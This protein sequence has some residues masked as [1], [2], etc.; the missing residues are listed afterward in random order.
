M[1]LPS[2]WGSGILHIPSGFRSFFWQGVVYDFFVADYIIMFNKVGQDPGE[3]RSTESNLPRG[4]PPRGKFPCRT[5]LEEGRID[6]AI[7]RGGATP[8]QPEEGGSDDE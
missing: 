8:S 7:C 2:V 4:R 1:G 5:C 3:G 6:M